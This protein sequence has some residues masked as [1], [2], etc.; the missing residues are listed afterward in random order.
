MNLEQAIEL[1]R[2][3]YE[4]AQKLSFV[5]KPLAFAFFYTWKKVDALTKKEKKD[6]RN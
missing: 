5:E 2:K 3:E 6:D 1:L 4:R